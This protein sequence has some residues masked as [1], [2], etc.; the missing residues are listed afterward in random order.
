MRAADGADDEVEGAGVRGRPVLV[1][2]RRDVR[3]RAE[4]EDVGLL[5]IAA[6]DAYDFVGAEGFGPED[7]EVAETACNKY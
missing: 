3:V 6:R 1:L 5:G 7:A 4:R 2:A